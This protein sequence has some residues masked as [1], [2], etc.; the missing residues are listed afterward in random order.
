VLQISAK[1]SGSDDPMRE[2]REYEDP[3][4]AQSGGDF[5]F[6]EQG[7]GKAPEAVYARSICNNCELKLT[8]QST[9]STMRFTES[10][11]DFQSTTV[12]G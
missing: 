1:L 8:V 11:V 3:L 12:N 4:C 5:W 9:E 2:P 7:L 10:G 6:P